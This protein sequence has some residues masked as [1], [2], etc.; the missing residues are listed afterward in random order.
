LW[1]GAIYFV[2]E[3]VSIP[4]NLGISRMLIIDGTDDGV[5]TNSLTKSADEAALSGISVNLS[6]VPGAAHVFRST[7]SERESDRQLARFISGD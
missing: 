6:L 5:A 1:R 4:S 7:A 2:P 3:V